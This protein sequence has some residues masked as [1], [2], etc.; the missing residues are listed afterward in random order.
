[1]NSVR[2]RPSRVCRELRAAPLM[3]GENAR[4]FREDVAQVLDRVNYFLVCFD[5][6][7]PVPARSADTGEDREFDSSGAR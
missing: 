5:R 2:A 3:I 6:S 4:L 1:M 7:C